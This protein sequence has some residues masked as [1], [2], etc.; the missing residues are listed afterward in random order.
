MDIGSDLQAY[1]RW[2]LELVPFSSFHQMR[3][4]IIAQAPAE[5]IPLHLT[6]TSLT[7]QQNNVNGFK[8]IS[9]FSLL[10]CYFNIDMYPPWFRWY[11]DLVNVFNFQ[12]IHSIYVLTNSTWIIIK[13]Q[14]CTGSLRC[15]RFLQC[16]LMVGVAPLRNMGTL[17]QSLLKV[18]ES[19]VIRNKSHEPEFVAVLGDNLNVF[20]WR[21][22]FV[23]RRVDSL[24]L[25]QRKNYL[26]SVRRIIH[27]F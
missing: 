3:D 14:V 6:K 8:F 19:F 27:D 13:Y 1:G 18:L 17:V 24:Q 20:L 5:T 21:V 26:L 10:Y 11:L 7:I 23:S 15:S 16:C 2:V 12:L 22:A 25:I 4:T 9:N